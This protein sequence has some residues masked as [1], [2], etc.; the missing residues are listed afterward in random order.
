VAASGFGRRRTTIVILVVVSILLISLDRRG[1]GAIDGLRR[2]ALDLFSPVRGVAKTVAR[3]FENAWHGVFDYDNVKRENELLREQ[4]D[5]EKGVSIAQEWQIKELQDLRAAMQLG[6]L[7]N[8]PQVAAEVVGQPANNS[9][10]SFTINKGASSGLKIGMP[11]ITAAG[12]VG[13]LGEVANDSAVVRLLWDPG[14]NVAAQIQGRRAPAVDPNS[15][16]SSPPAVPG[17]STTSAPTTTV[18][19]T[20][21]TRPGQTTTTA[22][23]TTLPPTTT[24]TEGPATTT[25]LPVKLID[26][27][28]VHG[29][30]EGEDLLLD[31][32]N[33]DQDV[34]VGDLVST[35]GDD[36]NLSPSGIPIGK[37]VEVSRRPGS[38]QLQVKV[39][40]FAD[41]ASQRRR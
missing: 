5:A 18:A 2:G 6:P 19:A 37:V 9:R 16:T 3:P 26:L 15:P 28:S 29:V 32:I 12:L 4:I 40:P 41:L 39:Q 23:T 27:G 30:G 25:T 1:N 22:S 38:T 31:Y 7:A 34:Q 8:V 20:K 21:P 13:R 36:R 35:G 14:V 17:E 24:T 11:V 10:L 33:K